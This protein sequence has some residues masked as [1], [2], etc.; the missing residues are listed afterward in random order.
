M[1]TLRF[2]N[3]F[4][5]SRNQPPATK[6]TFNRFFNEIDINGDDVISRREMAQ[7]VLNFYKPAVPTYHED[8]VVL[9]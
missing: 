8:D 3:D 7:F 1:E 9:Q 2:L 5:A 6:A 4:L